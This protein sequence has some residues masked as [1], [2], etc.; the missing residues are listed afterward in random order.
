MGFVNDTS[1]FTETEVN[2]VILMRFSSVA[3]QEVINMTTSV[4][5]GTTEKFVKTNHGSVT[6]CAMLAQITACCQ[7]AVQKQ[8]YLDS[9]WPNFLP[10][11]TEELNQV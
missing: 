3:G 4:Q 6:A 11:Q 8:S 5:V 7:I 10:S 1:A 2:V 9:R